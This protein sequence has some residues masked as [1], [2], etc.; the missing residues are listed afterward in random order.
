MFDIE[1]EGKRRIVVIHPCSRAHSYLVEFCTEVMMKKLADEPFVKTRHT[2]F[3]ETDFQFLTRIG[4][5]VA[6]TDSDDIPYL[7]KWIDYGLEGTPLLAEWVEALN[8]GEI[9]EERY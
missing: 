2:K 8:R 7:I 6:H 4:A 1:F 9:I 3:N 5:V